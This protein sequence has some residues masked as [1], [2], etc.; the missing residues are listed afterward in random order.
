MSLLSRPSCFPCS[1]PSWLSPLLARCSLAEEA[2]AAHLNSPQAEQHRRLSRLVFSPSPMLRPSWRLEEGARRAQEGRKT[3]RTVCRPDGCL[4]HQ[5]LRAIS[6][7]TA[8]YRQ[9][10]GRRARQRGASGERDLHNAFGVFLPIAA[11][12]KQWSSGA[13]GERGGQSG[14]IINNKLKSACYVGGGA[15]LG[16][17]C[18]V[19]GEQFARK[20][21]KFIWQTGARGVRLRVLV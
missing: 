11:P 9:T 17:L 18:S 19:L 20:C 5:L 15:V 2:P 21:I 13:V 10:S 1:P 6:D 16:T 4:W 12:L 3:R 7:S 14:E 8:F